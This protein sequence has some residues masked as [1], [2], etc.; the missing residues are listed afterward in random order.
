MTQK[1]EPTDEMKRSRHNKQKKHAEEWR[2]HCRGSYST[3]VLLRWAAFGP[4]VCHVDT[5]DVQAALS[6]QSLLSEITE[7]SLNGK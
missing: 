2:P 4:T 3:L 7:L 5:Y 6:T 1:V